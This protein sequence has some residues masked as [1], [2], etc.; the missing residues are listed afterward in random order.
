MRTATH[1]STAERFG[2]WLGRGWRG[3]VRREGQAVAWL[4][5]RGVP[6]FLIQGV[7]WFVKLGAL[8][9]SLYVGIWLTAICLGIAG[10]AWGAR[11]L[12]M[13]QPEPEW[14]MGHSGFG[15]YQGDMRIDM[16]DPFEDD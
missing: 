5:A 11:N 15:L 14:R 1:I 12:E 2:R 7:L 13:D 4:T 9:L 6:G 8:A 16:G 10:A 3:Y